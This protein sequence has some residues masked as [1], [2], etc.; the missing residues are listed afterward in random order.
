MKKLISFILFVC[1]T[2]FMA[3]GQTGKAPAPIAPYSQYVRAGNTIYIS[4]QIPV[5]PASGK[6]V[7]GDIRVQARQVMKNI[8]AILEANKMDYSNLVQCT[9][10]LTNL[11]NYVP[12]NEAYAEFFSGKYPARVA[13]QVVRLPMN[14]EI[15]IASVAVEHVPHG[16][17]K[18]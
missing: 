15:E 16:G 7:T 9:I 6:L 13:V 3:S 18:K 17:M 10:Y 8:G 11:D 14:A 4:G 1:L 12:V 2:G 5:D